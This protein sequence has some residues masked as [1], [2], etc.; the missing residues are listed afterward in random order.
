MAGMPYGGMGS[1]FVRAAAIPTGI[2]FG[3]QK[4]RPTHWGVER[5]GYLRGIWGRGVLFD[6][7]FEDNI[8]YQP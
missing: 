7:L 8:T 3:K 4:K 1:Y 6:T 2:V 5:L